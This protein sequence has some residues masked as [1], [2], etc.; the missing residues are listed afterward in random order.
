MHIELKKDVLLCRINIFNNISKPSLMKEK[1]SLLI[2]T[3]ILVLTSCFSAN[4]QSEENS[5]LSIRADLVNRYIWRGLNLGGSSAH[6]QPAITYSFADTGLEVGAW[7]SYPLALRS[8]GSETNLF[9]SYSPISW[10]NLT[11]C[12]YFFPA[13]E[14]LE[15]NAFFNYK[16]DQTSH[17][18]EAIITLGGSDEFPVY[19]TFG[20]NLYG[21]DGVNHLGEKY[22]AKYI[23]VGYLAS[24]REYAFKA[25]AGAAPDNPKT[26]LGG[27]GFYG[28]K[29]GLINLGISLGRDFSVAVKNFP[30]STSLI[31][32]PEAGNVYLVAGIT[33]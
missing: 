8:A 24:Y 31:T 19:A 25:F 26:N 21:A 12:D 7:A 17:T 6:I 11:V 20:I 29:A 14:P 3:G 1:L 32:N 28:E 33:L 5:N 15:R 18:L 27:V 16:E 22:N 2:V 13:D 9:V 10:L 23:E 30:I 4:A